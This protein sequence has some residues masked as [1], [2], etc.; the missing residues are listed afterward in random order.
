MGFNLTKDGKWIFNRRVEEVD[1]YHGDNPNVGTY[2]GS[3]GHL[4]PAGVKITLEPKNTAL[5]GGDKHQHGY[6]LNYEIT[7][8]Q[9]Y[10]LFEFE[11]LR[12]RKNYVALLE[13]P[14]W[15]MPTKTQVA[16]DITPGETKGIIKLTGSNYSD[17][18]KNLIAA[19]W[20][21]TVFLPWAVPS[22]GA[23]EKLSPIPETGFEH[24][25]EL[26]VGDPGLEFITPDPPV[27][28]VTEF[29]ALVLQE[30]AEPYSGDD[31]PPAL[32]LSKKIGSGFEEITQ[33][34]NYTVVFEG[35][36]YKVHYDSATPLKLGDNIKIAYGQS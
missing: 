11:K 14:L 32:V 2:A 25:Y 17:K 8:E 9:M 10:S 1:F 18:L 24:E 22:G 31:F 3:A 35:G 12:N 7:S 34:S 5:I 30:F 15:I 4:G 13:I 27:D 36:L 29:K 26:L 19:S 23:E 20:N 16:A 6:I 28:E 21:G 33:V